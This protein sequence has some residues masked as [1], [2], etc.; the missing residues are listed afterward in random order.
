M[1]KTVTGRLN[2][3]YVSSVNFLHSR[4]IYNKLYNRYDEE[5]IISFFEETGRTKESS[6]TE[7]HHFE[8]DF[9]YQ[10]ILI[11]AVNGV[12]GAGNDVQVTLDASN[13]DNGASSPKVTD[14]VLFN[15]NLTGYVI[16]KNTTTPT[17][18]VI[19]IR[20]VDTVNSDIVSASTVGSI[21]T[22]YSNSH[23]E[24]SRQ[25]EGLISKPL[26]FS[27]IH[28]IFKGHYSVTGT[29]ATNKIEFTTTNGKYYWMY[30]GEHDAFL[31]F[32]LDCA[33]GLL[34][35]QQSN[36]LTDAQGRDIR[37]TKGLS[38]W[39]REEGN[40]FPGGIGALTDIDTIIKV[41]DKQKG[42]KENLMLLG[43]NLDIDVD[44]V[45]IDKMVNGAIQYNTF[46]KGN[47][48]QRS[49]D[50]GFNS[51]RK[52]SYSFHK[53]ELEAFNHPNVTGSTGYTY[54][55][56][57]FIIPTDKGKDVKTGAQLDSICL[58]Y[59]KSPSMNRMY[60]H[61]LTGLLAPSPTNDIDE[62][63]FEYIC[64][65]GLQCFGLN[66]FMILE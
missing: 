29:E 34:F 5:S 14:L 62:L 61:K 57:G 12:P 26:R 39:I 45:L 15:N 23:A 36:G 50:L 43:I 59:K 16:T 47:G 7:F 37:V 32:R 54:P 65:K 3:T 1:S 21:L 55:D 40:I 9:I 25:P 33:F 42:S 64:E 53:K 58:R 4:E 30:E 56:K 63:G 17:A 24:G 52:G 28:Q 13:H 48:K 11:A 18:H 20:P 66:R 2:E 35:N 46:G 27:G 41:L 31:K 38:Q 44:N 49:I 6:Q 19:T 60:I 22:C 10:N 51:F 8:K